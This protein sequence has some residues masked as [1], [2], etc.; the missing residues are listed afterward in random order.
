[1]SYLDQKN[2]ARRG[3]A[4]SFFDNA[5]LPFEGEECLVWPFAKTRKGYGVLQYR[6]RSSSAHRVAC[7]IVHGAPPSKQHQAAHTCGNGTGGCV[8]PGH[9]RWAT[10]M[11][12]AADRDG[13]GMTARGE[14]NGAAKLTDRQA[15]EIAAR[16]S[17]PTCSDSYSKIAKQYGV[18]IYPIYSIAKGIN[19][20]GVAPREA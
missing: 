12:N 2:K 13:H 17:D 3:E 16:L 18:S 20:G 8:N 14:R 7:E 19:W 5:V 11:E 6:G 10:P 15:Q 1:M 4:A 9:V